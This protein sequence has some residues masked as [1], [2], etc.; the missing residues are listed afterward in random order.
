M[1]WL[2]S[3]EK[4]PDKSKHPQGSTCR[5]CGSPI[6]EYRYGN[7]F[8]HLSTKS[9]IDTGPEKRDGKADKLKTRP[10]LKEEALLS[11]EMSDEEIEE[12]IR[13]DLKSVSSRHG[14]LDLPDL[15]ESEDI[16]SPEDRLLT[17]LIDQSKILIRQNEL[18]LRLL[19]RAFPPFT[20]SNHGDFTITASGPA[21]HE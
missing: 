3:N 17:T 11:S 5:T 1:T 4:C 13:K 2:C 10:R 6:Q 16:D 20:R 12:L 21:T 7:L 14:W 19:R 18:I 8:R 15:L 9:K